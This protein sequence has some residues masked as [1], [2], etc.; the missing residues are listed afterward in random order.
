MGVW[1]ACGLHISVGWGWGGG[2]FILVGGPGRVWGVGGG[3]GGG[4]G[5]LSWMGRPGRFGGF[6]RDLETV[7]WWVSD[8]YHENHWGGCDGEIGG[9]GGGLCGW[10]VVDVHIMRVVYRFAIDTPRY[11]SV[12]EQFAFAGSL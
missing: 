12:N 10:V 4:G 7:G 6:G 11:N 3:G 1:L 9:R 2:G 8:E 5:G